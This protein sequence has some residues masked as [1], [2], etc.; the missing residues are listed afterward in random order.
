MVTFSEGGVFLAAPRWGWDGSR[1]LAGH[2]PWHHQAWME[3]P[4]HRHPLHDFRVIAQSQARWGHRHP[5]GDASQDA[6]T[7][8]VYNS[9]LL[10]P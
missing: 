5:E 8:P 1:S 3:L 2:L 10:A 9:E 6:A 7:R 4:L